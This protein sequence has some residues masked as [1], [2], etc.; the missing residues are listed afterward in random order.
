MKT[1]LLGVSPI[2]VL[3]PAYDHC[4]CVI[5]RRIAGRFV[6]RR[7]SFPDW[8][9]VSFYWC[10]MNYHQRRG[11]KQHAFILSQFPW[12]RSLGTAKLPPLLRNHTRLPSAV[13]CPHQR[14]NEGK[15]HSTLPQPGTRKGRMY[16]L[17]AVELTASPF[18][19]AG[20]RKSHSGRAP[21]TLL[22]TFT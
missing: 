16:F 20:R 4:I 19:K 14:L 6:G 18:L 9:C 15:I 12:S 17:V 22:K 7:E 2:S 10:I 1:S 8:I 11:L 3:S 13:L 5:K 21:A